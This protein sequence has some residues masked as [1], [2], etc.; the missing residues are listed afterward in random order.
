MSWKN[1]LYAVLGVI[2]PLAFQE[3]ILKFPEFPLDSESFLQLGLWL[4]GLVVGGW[5]AASLYHRKKGN[6]Q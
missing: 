5:N 6:L 3:L 4:I 1:L 2:I